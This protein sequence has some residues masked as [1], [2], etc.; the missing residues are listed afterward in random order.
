MKNK[1]SNYGIVLVF[2]LA[3]RAVAQVS[4]AI[5]L[6]PQPTGVVFILVGVA[7]FAAIIGTIQRNSCTLNL[8]I[9]IAVTDM[10]MALGFTTGSFLVGA[11]IAD[12]LL[13]WLVRKDQVD[14][15]SKTDLKQK[16]DE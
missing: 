8:V 4:G 13:I 9:S 12:L 14:L 1:I 3:L 5:S 15:P 7:Y 10:L 11:V 2:I 16:N 6:I